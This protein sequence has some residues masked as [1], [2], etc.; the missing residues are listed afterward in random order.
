[1]RYPADPTS[2]TASKPAFWARTAAAHQAWITAWMS[3]SVMARGISPEYLA[4][5]AEGARGASPPSM[6]FRLAYRPAW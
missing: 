5:T 4:Y 1:M 2:S 6:F 3:S